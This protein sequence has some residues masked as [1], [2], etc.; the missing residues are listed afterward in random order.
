LLRKLLPT[1]LLLSTPSY[2]TDLTIKAGTTYIAN[3][4]LQLNQLRMEDGATL[5]APPGALDWNIQVDKAWLTGSSLIN[6]RGKPGSQGGSGPSSQPASADNCQPGAAGTSGQNGGTGL[7]GVNLRMTM[8]IVKFDHLTIDTRGGDGGNGGNGRDGGKGGKAKGCNG[9]DGGAGGDAGNGGDG[10]NGGEV[11]ITYRLIGERAS[12]PIT[13]F[14][15]GLTVSTLGGAAGSPGLPGQG[16][17]GG[18][19]RFEKRTTHITVTRDPG[20]QGSTGQKGL[21]GQ[22]GITGKSRI[23]NQR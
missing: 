16:G 15:E 4:D 19:G 5:M 22:T 11:S 10:G 18:K 2:A 13:N 21:T 9:G 1:L 3:G 12:L 7:P 8:N 14:G 17:T 23:I 20:N 6:A